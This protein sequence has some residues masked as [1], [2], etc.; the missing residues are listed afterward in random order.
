M[1]FDLANCMSKSGAYNAG[2]YSGLSFWYK[3][4]T[5]VRIIIAT[6]PVIPT[7]R[8]GTCTPGTTMGTECDNG[9]GADLAAA[10]AG[11]TTSVTFATLTQAFGQMKAFDKTQIVNIQW[12]VPQGMAFDFTIDDVAFTP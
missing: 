12:Q 9:H 2:V 5:A 3:S 7:S 10:P 6:M 4:T 8:G 1:G 11:M